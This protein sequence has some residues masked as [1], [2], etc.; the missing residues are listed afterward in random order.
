MKSH[1]QNVLNSRQALSHSSGGQDVGRAGS[2]RGQEGG[3]APGLSQRLGA[4][5]SRAFLGSWKHHRSLCLHLCLH[6]PVR[7]SV[8]FPI[9]NKDTVLL[10]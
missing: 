2:F 5:G 8:E 7:L 3:A 6:V 4:A 1:K 9:Y 10:D